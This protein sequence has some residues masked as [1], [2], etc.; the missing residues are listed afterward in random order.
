MTWLS[1]QR[2][3]APLALSDRGGGR[4]GEEASHAHS[5]GTLADTAGPGQKHTGQSAG[6]DKNLHRIKSDI[7]IL[8]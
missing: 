3:N 5:H 6:R 8:C 2:S 4:A 7:Y 1:K